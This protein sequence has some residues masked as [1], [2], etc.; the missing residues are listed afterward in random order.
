MFWA[1][2][3]HKMEDRPRPL[4]VLTAKAGKLSTSGHLKLPFFLSAHMPS[5]G[6]MNGPFGMICDSDF[7]TEV[8]QITK[9]KQ[10]LFEPNESKRYLQFGSNV[11]P[12][13][14]Q[15]FEQFQM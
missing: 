4:K 11:A 1:Q 13:T 15:L 3:Q 10:N 8:P 6:K 9:M 12:T 7:I 2:Q 14:M 5:F